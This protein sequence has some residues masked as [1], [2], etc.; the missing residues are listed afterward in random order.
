VI[1]RERDERTSIPENTSMKTLC[2]RYGLFSSLALSCL[3]SASTPAVAQNAAKSTP[4]K[5]R[6][7]DGLYDMDDGGAF[8][9]PCEHFGFHQVELND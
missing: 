8:F 7:K 1:A 9:V 4:E 6:P 5:W 2:R 3:I